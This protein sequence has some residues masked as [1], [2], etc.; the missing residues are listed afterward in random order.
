MANLHSCRSAVQCGAV[1][2]P[3]SYCYCRLNRCVFAIAQERR[4]ASQRQSGSS[5][6]DGSRDSG[7]SVLWPVQY[8]LE[9]IF[10]QQRQAPQGG[11][12]AAAKP[13]TASRAQVLPQ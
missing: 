12:A 6:G 10:W 1:Q 13:R 8:V 11:S 5:S 2:Y 4:Y 7:G 9:R 3:P